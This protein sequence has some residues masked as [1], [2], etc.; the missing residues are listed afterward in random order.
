MYVSIAAPKLMGG[1]RGCA[2]EESFQ[3]QSLAEQ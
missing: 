2:G 3:G 1:N